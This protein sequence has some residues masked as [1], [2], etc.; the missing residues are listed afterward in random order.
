MRRWPGP[1]FSADAL[2]AAC[3]HAGAAEGAAEGALE[4][5]MAVAMA[6]AFLAEERRAA[7]RRFGVAVL[8]Q[9]AAPASELRVACGTV[10]E[11]HLGVGSA[12]RV[13]SDA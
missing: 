8:A 4:V 5:A 7:Q 1:P 9:V 3:C 2:E 11:G 12:L 10:V 6:V 13:S